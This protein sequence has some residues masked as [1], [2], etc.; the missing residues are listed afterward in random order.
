MFPLL[1]LLSTIVSA[2]SINPFSLSN[3]VTGLITIQLF[4]HSGQGAERAALD[5]T[6]SAFNDSHPDIHV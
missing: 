5:A 2:C 6:L 3:S 4:Y 1:I